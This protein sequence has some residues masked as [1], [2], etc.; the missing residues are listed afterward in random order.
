M[1]RFIKAGLAISCL[2]LQQNRRRSKPEA[3]VCVPVIVL[4]AAGSLLAGT[5]A[6]AATWPQKG[7]NITIIVNYA[8]GGTID[9]AARL[10]A[11]YIE[12][13]LG[14]KVEVLA[15]P[16]AGGQ[17]GL[18]ELSRARARWIHCVAVLLARWDHHLSQPGCQSDLQARELSA[19]SRLR[20]AAVAY[21]GK[22]RLPL[23]DDEGHRRS[24]LGRIRQKP[25]WAC[26]GR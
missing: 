23:Y 25:P 2:F 13:E 21:G 12:K 11:P 4:L 5:A 1:G 17:I 3:S 18:T 19:H 8:A 16:G 26:L 7:K 20:Q 6:R 22:S 15:K 9:V 10:I 14:T 24:R